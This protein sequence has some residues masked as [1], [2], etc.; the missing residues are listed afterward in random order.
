MFELMIPTQ[1]TLKIYSR[2]K[3]ISE[4]SDGQ[5]R[6]FS[7]K[8]CLNCSLRNVNLSS[9]FLTSSNNFCF[10]DFSPAEILKN[11][12]IFKFEILSFSFVL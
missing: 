4:K 11:S 7:A 5:K 8:I 9:E 6:I 2:T 10:S 3:D 12:P 1:V